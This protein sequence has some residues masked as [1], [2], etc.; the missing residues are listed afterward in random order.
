MLNQ[1]KGVNA[2]PRKG[3]Q[4]RRTKINARTMKFTG[5]W[6]AL[7]LNE[8]RRSHDWLGHLINKDLYLPGWPNRPQ[9][10]GSPRRLP[11]V[12]AKQ[13]HWSICWFPSWRDLTDHNTAASP[14]TE[15]ISNQ[16]RRRSLGCFLLRTGSSGHAASHRLLHILLP[17][18]K[19]GLK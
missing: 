11:E 1:I 9:T 4:H 10:T 5:P 2:L 12:S 13:R 17:L 16:R 14:T 18:Q 19:P 6:T 7:S 15:I 3:L 8:L